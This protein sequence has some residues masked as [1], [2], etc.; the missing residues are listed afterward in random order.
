MKA[1]FSKLGQSFLLPISL[2]PA[3]GIML[4]IGGSLTNPNMLEAYNLAGVFG[5]ETLLGKFLIIMNAAGGVVLDNL[6]VMFAIALAIAFAKKEKGA[7]ALA[8]LMAYLVMNVA[9]AETMSVFN[10]AAEN[11]EVTIYGLTFSGMTASVLGVNNTLSMGVFGGIIAGGIT[12]ILHNKYIDAELPEVL[13]FF[14]GPR[15]VPIVAS[16]SALFYGMILVL[17]WPFFGGLLS[18]MGSTLGTLVEAGYGFIASF[19]FGVIERALIPFGLHHV[20]Y[21]P[22]WQTSV[23]GTYDIG[24]TV[25]YGTQNAFFQSLA[26]GDFTNFPATNFMSGKFPFMMFGLPA[27][28][29]AMYSCAD[30]ENRKEVSGLLLSVAVTSML[31]GVTEPIEFT[32]LFLA[33]VLYYGIH[34]PLAGISFMLMD[35]LHVKIGMTLSGGLIDYT[36]FGI[37]PGVTGADNNWYLVIPVGIVY[38]FVYYYLFKW[39]ILKFDIATPGR[40]GAAAVM[41]SKKEYND[42]KNSKVSDEFIWD[43]ID[44]FGGEENIVDVTACITRLR[45]TVKDNSLVKDNSHWKTLGASGVVIN[46]NAIQVIYGAKAAVYKDRVNES[47]GLE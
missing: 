35:L 28:A 34:V 16:F 18:M 6:P 20:F 26:T 38:A 45:V 23:G 36:L 32:F 31:T 47:L 29:Y 21:L 39:Y 1:F 4:G 37:L 40:G 33:P 8:A 11:G 5:Q 41:M 14:S 10:I 44:A 17:I 27:A 46:G 22:L 24:G 12:A 9:I 25:V 13:G 19:L 30:E 3:A 42:K 2:L 43:V 15:L 7:A